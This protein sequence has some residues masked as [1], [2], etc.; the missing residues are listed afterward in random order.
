MEG[1][2]KLEVDQ[3]Q[4][5]RFLFLCIANDRLGFGHLHRLLVL[6]EEFSQKKLGVDF[7]VFGS[8]QASVQVSE[9]GY[10]CYLVDW[11]G[12]SNS[13]LKFDSSKIDSSKYAGIVIDTSH[14]SFFS[15]IEF[16]DFLFWL[17]SIEKLKVLIDSVGRESFVERFSEIQI[18]LQI[19]PYVTDQAIS[20]RPWR[21]LIG[22]KF[23]ILEASFGLE[24]LHRVIRDEAVKVMITC[25]GSDPTHLS[26]RVLKNLLDFNW[27]EITL[28]I[29][30]LF[31]PA[32]RNYLDEICRASSQLISVV[33]SPAGLS[34]LMVGGDFA[35][36][37]SGLTKYELAAS[38]TPAILIS[39][40]SA[41][42]QANK[43]FSKLG[44]IV[45]LGFP[46]SDAD[47]K[48]QVGKLR[49][50]RETRRLMSDAGKRIVDG[51]GSQR[52]V[53]AVLELMKC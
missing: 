22:P 9:S 2:E 23:T 41:H 18:D 3:S 38:G 32:Y 6:A 48:N 44:S 51:R 45:D 5:T 34:E 46:W 40:D 14:P 52:I 33:Y 4:T 31:S 11:S 15:I 43:S 30:P 25:G 19:I 28:V 42:D 27:L 36:A 7:L 12:E 37:T 26:G 16:S 13:E 50:D 24:S 17:S 49:F 8:D 53:T 39:I 35:I 29:G 1:V 21:Q 10:L 20:E 47:L